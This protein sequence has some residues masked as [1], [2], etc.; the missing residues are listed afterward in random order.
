L[1]IKQNKTIMKKI[2]LTFGLIAGAIITALMYGSFP[3]YKRG[4]IS[5]DSG[6]LIGYTSMVIA[7]SMVFFGIKS[8]RDNH[9][10][11]VISFGKALSVG[12]AIA[13]VAGL[14]YAISWEFYLKFLEPNFMEEYVAMAIEK[15]KKA[16]E[17]E[18]EIQKLIA[19]T[20][21]MKEW[22]KNPLLR[23]GMTLAEILP[24]G[25][26][27]SFIS[28]GLLRKKSFLPTTPTA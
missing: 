12:L 21:M 5:Y 23:F 14:C 17:P 24:V 4:V 19:N 11:G 7:L 26:L 8:Y 20:N 25:I 27:L 13:G 1:A 2:I 28:A 15:A 22:Y 6:E 18:A 16:G 9:L 3:L 10:N